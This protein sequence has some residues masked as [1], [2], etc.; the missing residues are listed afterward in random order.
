MANIGKAVY[1]ILSGASGV[2][3][4]TS[5]RIYP[6]TVPQNAAFPYAVFQV[7]GTQPTDTK[8]GVSKLDVVRVQVDCY[9]ENYDTTDTL[10]TAIRAALDRY[11][12]TPSGSGV[13]IDK[14]VFTNQ[15]SGA[16]DLDLRVFWGSLDFDIRVRL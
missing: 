13:A 16:P 8:E 7:I 12:G 9:S 10:A 15:V 5:T 14:I 4:I 6:D 3:A 2:T 1:T 11:A